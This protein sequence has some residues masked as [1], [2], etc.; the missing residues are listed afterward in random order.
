MA[1]TVLDPRTALLVIDLQQGL[2]ATP[3]AHPIEGIVAG[4]A[5]L[6]DAFRAASLPVVLAVNDGGPAPRTD[7]SRPPQQLPEGFAEIVPE[8]GAHPIDIVVSRSAWSAFAGTGL[9]EK[10][11]ALRVTQVVIVGIA[12]SFGVESTA[13]AAHDLGY[14]VTLPVDAITDMSAE[15][16]DKSVTRVFPALAETGTVDEVLAKLVA[17]AAATA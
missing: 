17:G 6:A 3:K 7:Y 8:L 14:H 16:H 9:D 12:T 4:A 15:S 10:L 11:R 2:V 5:R 13:R 1:I